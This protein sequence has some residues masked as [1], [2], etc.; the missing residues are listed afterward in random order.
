MA[1]AEYSGYS[2]GEMIVLR[3]A[4]KDMGKYLFYLMLSCRFIEYCN[5]IADGVKMPR[6]DVHDILN[7]QIPLIPYQERSQITNFL[8]RETKQIDELVSKERQK[9]EFIKQYRQ[10]LISQTVTGKIDLREVT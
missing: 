5:A 2:L 10:A 8:D 6:T 3:P 4:L 7:A 1:F 9:I